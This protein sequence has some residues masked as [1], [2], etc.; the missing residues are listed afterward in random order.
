MNP[1]NRRSFLKGSSITAAAAS[2]VRLPPANAQGLPALPSPHSDGVVRIHPHN[3]R[4]L[5]FRNKPLVLV[6]ATEHYGS[7]INL[8]FDFEKYL[9]DT[10][11]HNLTLTR[12]F[13]LYRELQSARNPCS[14][15]KPNSPEFV[16]PFVRTGPGKAL[17]GEPIY[18][19]DQWN[20]VYFARLHRF[21]NLASKKGII[22]E[23]TLFSNSYA[24]DIWALNPLRAAN[25][26]QHV[27]N[28]E[29]Q[30]YL[31]L[32]NPE[33]VSRQKTY[34]RKILQETSEYDNVYY[35]ICNEPGGGIPG[36]VTPEDVNAWQKEMA[37]TARSEMRRLGRPHLISGKLSFVYGSHGAPNR[38]PMDASLAGTIFDIVNN[39]PLP[40][41]TL[42]GHTY[43]LGAFMSK[44]LRLAQVAAFCKAASKY[45][46]PV[47]L[48]EDNAASLYR[49]TTGWT[50]DRKRAWTALMNGCNYDLI[51]FSITVG[52]ERGTPASRRELRSW[53][54]HLSD[55]MSSFD[56]VGSTLDPGWITEHPKNLLLSGRS[57]SGR[58]YIAYLADFREVTDPTAGREI[59]GKISFAL[60]P[61]HYEVSLYSPTT[62]EASPRI[63]IDTA[64]S[65]TLNLAPFKE[66]LVIRATR[67][68][69]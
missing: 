46:K 36:H 51:D 60:P 66:D 25:N 28:V 8:R 62:G 22:A 40:E 54:K 52:S 44:E 59:S 57:A 6:T 20:P 9:E 15:L 61:A 31:S 38:F 37:Q 30:E 63:S 10:A 55:F 43:D 23:L 16:T 5:L 7:V 11:E 49:D 47:V 58:D 21:L 42:D 41:T 17:D 13:L 32:K 48:D 50:I 34:L 4:Y 45:P 19:L 56:L 68:R 26:V 3:P 69:T 35:E 18:D 29:W 24:D 64:A 12:T 14:P 27:G 39:H 53:M 1:M 65:Q 33:L 67:N 2:L